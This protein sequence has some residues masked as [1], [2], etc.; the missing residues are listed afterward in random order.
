MVVSLLAPLG[1]IE[2]ALLPLALELNARGHEVS[3]FVLSPPQRPNQNV[4]PLDDAGIVIKTASP[5]VVRL[6]RLVHPH[7]ARIAGGA[8]ALAAAGALPFVAAQALMRQR[9]VGS[10]V[11]DVRSRLWEMSLGGWPSKDSCIAD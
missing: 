1:G 8:S 6:A 7:R 2:A 5:L 3:V 4:D 9:P 11:R 10:A